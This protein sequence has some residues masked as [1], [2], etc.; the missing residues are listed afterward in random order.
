MTATEER[1]N[2]PKLSGQMEEY[3]TNHAIF[4]EIAGEFPFQKPTVW[5]VVV[6][7]RDEILPNDEFR[8]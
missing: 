1:R 5:E 2:N 4:P 3:F 7:G 8:R 6:F